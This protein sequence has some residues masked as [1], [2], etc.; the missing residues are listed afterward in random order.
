MTS[1]ST[2][3]ERLKQVDRLDDKITAAHVR[4]AES[5]VQL[6]GLK[7]SAQS[8][9]LLDAQGY[10]EGPALLVVSPSGELI[11]NSNGELLLCED[12]KKIPTLSLQPKA[13]PQQK[14]EDRFYSLEPKANA[15]RFEALREQWILTTKAFV[16]LAAEIAEV[17]SKNQPQQPQESN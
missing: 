9:R 13:K 6:L 12:T 10:L 1:L 16:E 17:R 2:Q 3:L 7:A 8:L 5:I 14:I 4:F 15:R 11:E